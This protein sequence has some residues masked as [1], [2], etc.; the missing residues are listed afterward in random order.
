MDFLIVKA[1]QDTLF[2]NNKEIID[3]YAS[4]IETNDKKEKAQFF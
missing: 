3:H 4:I 2:H 1:V